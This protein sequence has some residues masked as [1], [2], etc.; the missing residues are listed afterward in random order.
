MIYFKIF[1]TIILTSILI[2]CQK[3]TDNSDTNKMNKDKIQTDTAQTRTNSNSDVEKLHEDYLSAWKRGDS[4][5]AMSYWADDI[6][7]YVP[8][9]NPHSGIY[10]GKPEVQRNLI[11]RIIEETL[12]AEVL[13][14]DDLA[15]GSD[16]V[17]T[18]V[19]ERFTKADG[20][21]FETKRIV[22]YRWSNQKIIEVRYFD[23]D[24]K[25]ADAFWSK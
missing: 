22:I 24:Q 15:I 18:I 7:M 23:P 8:G 10:S 21:V 12:N 4:N 3:K 9:S 6:I 19:H 13:G 14:L 5:A 2:S 20:R 11:D 1:S 25:A 16:H 17:F